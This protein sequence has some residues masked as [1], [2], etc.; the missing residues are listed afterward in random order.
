V[1]LGVDTFITVIVL[2]SLVLSVFIGHGMQEQGG[3]VSVP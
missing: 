2:M 1:G 3:K